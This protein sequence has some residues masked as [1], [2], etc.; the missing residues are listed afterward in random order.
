MVVSQKSA[1]GFLFTLFFSGM[2]IA[3]VSA[4]RPPAPAERPN[5]D[6]IVG[7]VEQAALANRY[8]YR[9]YV[10]TR[11]YLMYGGE[12]SQKPSS[13]VVAEITFVPPTTKEYK[14]LTAHGSSRGEG[15]VRRILESESKATATGNAPGAVSRENYNF[16]Y[17]GEDVLNGH[18]C[19]ILGLQPKHKEKNLVAGRAWVDQDT[20]LVR[21]VQGE[22]AKLPSWWLKSV[23][24]TLDFNEVGGMWLQTQT[25]AVAEVRVFGTHVLTAQAVKFQAAETVA[26]NAPRRPASHPGSARRARSLIGAVV[27]ER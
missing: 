3:Q 9:P 10:L 21:R 19:Y 4:P 6:T 18:R 17:L 24:V 8:H 12:V 11:E 13:E 25:K 15:V 14:I 23:N 1:L 16:S 22:M 2:L 26:Q 27:P 20:F 5:V 7:R